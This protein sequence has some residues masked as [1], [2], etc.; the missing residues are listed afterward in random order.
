MALTTAA[1]V[2]VATT[3]LTTPAFAAPVSVVIDGVTYSAD[4]GN[5]AAGATA[6][7]YTPGPAA[8]VIPPSVTIGAVSY[9]VTAIGDDAFRSTSITS[10]TL[11]DSLR[12]IGAGAFTNAGNVQS[13]TIPDSV[14]SIGAWAFDSMDLRTVTIG[15]GITRIEEQTFSNNN[16]LE[17]VVI[18]PNVTF[19]GIAAFAADDLRSLTIGS[20][21]TTIGDHAFAHNNRLLTIVIPA[22]VTSL[23]DS[24]FQAS[25]SSAAFTATFEG[26]APASIGT[27][28]FAG[29][30][31]TVIH[32]WRFGSAQVA[33]GFTA[34]T[35]QG[36]TTR[37]IATLRFDAA[38]HGTAPADQDVVV[39][40]AA[41][42]PAAPTASGFTF[43]GWTPTPGAG[44]FDFA[45]PV[46]RDLTLT[47]QW[48]TAPAAT[49]PATGRPAGESLTAALALLL[50]GVALV[51]AG[52]T[53]RRSAVRGALRR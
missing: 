6:T 39:G 13:I 8:I 53:R 22:S 51:I 1:L 29:A 41:T 43:T 26:A 49:L 23:G 21:V 46:T 47:A 35:W 16:R 50:A 48:A 7:S 17:S 27:G 2:V 38:G 52:S 24:V 31:G 18:P 33:G 19:I 42:A 45:T 32:R 15:T 4:D 30:T 25:S 9:P 44:T 28:T 36:L 34:P 12:T 37:A 20:G 11:P 14:T 3:T 10:I 5:V 40:T